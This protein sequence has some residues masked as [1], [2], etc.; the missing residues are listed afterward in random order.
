METIYLAYKNIWFL[1]CTYIDK[2][3]LHVKFTELKDDSILNFTLYQKNQPN[4]TVSVL[5]RNENMSD[6]ISFLIVEKNDTI[7]IRN[8]KEYNELF[9]PEDQ[10]KHRV[11]PS[12]FNVNNP[13]VGNLHPRCKRIAYS[14]NKFFVY[15]KKKCK[16]IPKSNNIHVLTFY[17]DTE[18][19]NTYSLFDMTKNK[20]SAINL[21][22]VSDN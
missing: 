16:Y 7:Y 21:S 10:K 15:D 17:H 9:S 11:S 8:D 1:Y 18:R 14:D 2:L 20:I 6:I 19:T 13:V 5:V 4:D 12:W 3:G 22:L